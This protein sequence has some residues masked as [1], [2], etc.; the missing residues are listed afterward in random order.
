[1]RNVTHLVGAAVWESY[2]DVRRCN[3]TGGSTSPGVGFEGSQPH[4][5]IALPTRPHFQCV[6]EMWPAGL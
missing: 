5:T 1:M 3:L 4:V 2:G 6:D